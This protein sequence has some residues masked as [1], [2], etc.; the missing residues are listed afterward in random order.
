MKVENILGAIGNTPHVRLKNLFGNRVQVW[1]KIESFNPGHSIKDRIALA[2]IEDA[3]KRGILTSSSV[4][5]EPTSGNTGIGL[6]MV[7]AVKRYR[8]ILVMPESMTVERRRYMAAL[9]AELVLTPR[10]RGMK[11]AIEK[12]QELLKE[13]PNS[14]MPMQFENEANIAIHKR[15]TALEIL[16]D[17]PD[18]IDYLITGVGTGGHITGCAEILKGKFPALKVFAVE[19]AKSPVISGGTHSPHKI[20]GIG[21]GFIPKNLHTE[22]LDGTIQVTE[23]EA[24]Q[25]AVRSAKEEGIFL[26]ISSGASLAAVAKKLP[27]I[28]DGKTILTFAYDTGERYLSIEGLFVA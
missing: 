8:C 2:M 26:G 18:G 27:E 13:I 11:G 9:G 10:E 17:F 3:E 19:P 7:A 24:F 22:I 25:F 20:Q 16:N 5:V 6:A 12:A 23:E 14:W 21:A 28:P 1:S 15:T 4:I